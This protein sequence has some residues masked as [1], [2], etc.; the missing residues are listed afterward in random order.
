[1]SKKEGLSL[2]SKLR[3]LVR[4]AYENSEDAYW[5]KEADARLDRLKDDDFISHEAFWKKAGL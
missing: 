4:D 2:S 5:A 1:M 3:D